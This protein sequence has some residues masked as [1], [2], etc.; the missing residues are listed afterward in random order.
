MKLDIFKLADIL[1]IAAV[2]LAWSHPAW[3][4][5]NVTVEAC[6]TQASTVAVD[7]PAKVIAAQEDAFQKCLAARL[8]DAQRRA[9]AVLK[10]K[11]AACNDEADIDAKR[12]SLTA[13]E[14]T[15]SYNK[16]MKGRGIVVGQ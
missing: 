13:A 2:A 4:Q 9:L 1:A 7:S 3:A 10:N 8:P 15:K 16:C 12:D 5:D 11:Q 14:R 6:R